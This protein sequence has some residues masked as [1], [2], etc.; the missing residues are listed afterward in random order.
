MLCS[1]GVGGWGMGTAHT[2]SPEPWEEREHVC[3]MHGKMQFQV[4]A[5]TIR[6]A[7]IANENFMLGFG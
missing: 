1:D 3:H 6:A 4:S 2:R 7:F 5:G